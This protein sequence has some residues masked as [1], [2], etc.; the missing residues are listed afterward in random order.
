[1]ENKWREIRQARYARLA[2]S[3]PA[4]HR[5]LMRFSRA[6]RS[7]SRTSAR[8]QRRYRRGLRPRWRLRRRC[9]F[10]QQA[11]ERER[12][13]RLQFKK[14]TR[15]MDGSSTELGKHSRDSHWQSRDSYCP[16]IIHT[17]PSRRRVAHFPIPSYRRFP[18]VLP[19]SLLSRRPQSTGSMSSPNRS[20]FLYH[21]RGLLCLFVMQLAN[22]STQAARQATPGGQTPSTEHVRADGG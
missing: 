18:N 8:S 1:M 13:P 12:L 7:T 11:P 15:P 17:R 16:Q 21:P 14:S 2:P 4:A 6:A 9:H 20:Y 22:E 3:A 10:S 5:I 19:P